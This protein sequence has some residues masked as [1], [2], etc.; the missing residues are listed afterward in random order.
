MTDD[1]QQYDRWNSGFGSANGR[2]FSL[3]RV[4]RD[5]FAVEGAH[6]FVDFAHG[7]I[8]LHVS[9]GGSGHG[10][11]QRAVAVDAFEKSGEGGDGFIGIGGG[12]GEARFGRDLGGGTTDVQTGDGPAGMH[13]EGRSVSGGRR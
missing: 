8:L 1:W 13:P 9:A 10:G 11:E 3:I 7:E 4:L 6:L 12:G 2:L 5:G